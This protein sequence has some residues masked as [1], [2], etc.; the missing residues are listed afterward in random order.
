MD[1]IL[2]AYRRAE[3]TAFKQAISDFFYQ[4]FKPKAES[5]F[6]TIIDAFYDEYSPEM[7]V[8]EGYT[9]SKTGGLYDILKISIEPDGS[10][11]MYF[12]ETALR[13]RSGYAGEDG[14]YDQ[15]F[16][17]GWHGGADK[18]DWTEYEKNGETYKTYIPHPSTGT[19][20]WRSAG[21]RFMDW[22]R[23]AQISSTPPLIAFQVLMQDYWNREAT[24]WCQQRLNYYLSNFK[25]TL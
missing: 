14:L 22:S 5:L 17:K 8:R 10:L 24:K 2:S 7:Y 23:P 21:K 13:F 9:L 20:Y 25:I 16:R 6:I 18:G 15:V 19:P 12:D 11:S 1:D 3:E 4:E